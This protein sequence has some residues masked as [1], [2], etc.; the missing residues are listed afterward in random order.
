MKHL[1]LAAMASLLILPASA[2]TLKT[3]PVIKEMK[4]VCV[5]ELEAEAFKQAEAYCNCLTGKL[6]KWA[7]AETGIEKQKRLW[8]I[9]IDLL[10]EET[11]DEE[12]YR[13]TEEAGISRADLETASI[14][15]FYDIEE[16]LDTCA[17]PYE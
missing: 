4:K 7:N 9:Q 17:A 1:I 10:P 5:A 13:R 15:N 6:K 11:T 2:E 8:T 12:I 16:F 14:V 3:G